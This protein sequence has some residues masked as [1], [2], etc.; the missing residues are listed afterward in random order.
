[1]LSAGATVFERNEFTNSLF[2]VVEGGVEVQVDEDDPSITVSLGQGE[3]FGEMGLI[4]GR[5]RTATV[6]A[7]KDS[8]LIE[9]PRRTMIKIINSVEEGV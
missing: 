7:G 1:M 2:A 8:F 9:V 6:K 3:F 5:R 4:A